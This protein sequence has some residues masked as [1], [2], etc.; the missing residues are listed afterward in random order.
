[1]SALLH[2]INKW[3]WQAC[4]SVVALWE[5]DDLPC[6]STFLCSEREEGG[7]EKKKDCAQTDWPHS[8]ARK[9]LCC[10]WWV[11]GT[12]C[13]YVLFNYIKAIFTSNLMEVLVVISG[14]ART[15]KASRRR[16]GEEVDFSVFPFYVVHC[17]VPYLWGRTDHLNLCFPC[18]LPVKSCSQQDGVQFDLACT[19]ICSPL[20]LWHLTTFFK[21]QRFVFM[22]T[23]WQH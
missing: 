18:N 22:F 19:F 23:L 14:T 2:W 6:W 5:G 16:V 10:A 21:R 3:A 13:W 12:V 1:M 20:S 15:W 9:L 4:G 7:E 8:L 11:K 17:C